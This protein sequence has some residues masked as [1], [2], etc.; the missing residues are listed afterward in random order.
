MTSAVDPQPVDLSVVVPAHNSV[1]VIDRT[2]EQ[3]VGRLSGTAAEII[4]VENGSTDDTFDTCRRLADRWQGSGVR[5]AVL[6]S[7]KGMGNAYRT[8]IAATRGARVLLTADDLP[9]GFDDLDALDERIAA[10]APM[11]AVMIGSKAHPRSAV[12]RGALRGT[13]TGGFSAMCRLIL[14]MRTRDP[15]GTFV[16]D[17]PLARQLAPNIAEAGFLF[18][19]EL[20]H[21]LERVGIRPV[22]VPVTLRASHREHRS[23]IT[24]GDMVSMGVGLLRVRA[25]HRGRW[26]MGSISLGS[27]SAA[28]GA[29]G[30]GSAP[31]AASGGTAEAGTGSP[32]RSPSR[33]SP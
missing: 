10:E 33:S 27:A 3:L 1:A 14:G 2:V 31:G 32:P 8:G 5:I 21:V 4:L 29:T 6:R 23:R 28:Q 11:P 18:S 25:R 20:V 12:H 26:R 13:L 30:T 7:D 22:E 16:I 9:F 19:T 17:G 24:P 15:Q